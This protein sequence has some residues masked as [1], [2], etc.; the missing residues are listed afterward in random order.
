MIDK[1]CNHI[2]RLQNILQVDCK[3]WY[4]VPA[5]KYFQLSLNKLIIYTV[6]EEYLIQ[7]KVI[8]SM[9]YKQPPNSQD[10]IN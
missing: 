1:N 9:N 8:F 2:Q 6:P 4:K 7:A 10:N 3:S 5:C